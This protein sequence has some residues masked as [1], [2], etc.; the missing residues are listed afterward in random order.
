MKFTVSK[1]QMLEG[2][3]N[4]QSVVNTRTTLPVLSNVLVTASD[5]KVWLTTTDLEVSVRVGVEAKVE[6][7]GGTTL[8]ARR[9]ASIFKEMPVNE[10]KV[11]SGSDETTSIQSGSA[12]FKIIGIPQED[13]PPLPSFEGGFTYIL[14][15][16]ALRDMLRQTCYAVSSDETRYILNGELLSFKSEKLTVVATDGRRLALI[17]NEVEFPEDA[18]RD[19]VVPTKTLDEL[20]RTLGDEGSVR[21]QANEN[22]VS[23]S[24]DDFLVVSKLIE[25]TYPNFR[26]VIPAQCE[27]RVTVERE[28]ML[29]ATRRMALL[30]S[31][32]SNAIRVIFGRNRIEILASSPDVGEARET[33]P[34]KYEGK[35]IQISFNPGFLIDPLRNIP[36]DEVF[37]ELT[38]DVSPGVIKCDFPFIYVLMPMRVS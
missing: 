19:L 13:F 7:E 9:I 6:K 32:K 27:E 23:F 29:A 35:D 16:S 25:G 8:P 18:E 15:Q 20:V 37:F 36:S 17:E 10:V 34:V 24:Y 3:Q 1:D 4:V 33:I 31:D 30:T 22:Q 5:G 11:E 26:Q 12:F 14:E 28:V 38:D 21:I 2:L